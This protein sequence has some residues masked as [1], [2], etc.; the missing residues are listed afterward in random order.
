[1]KKRIISLLLALMIILPIMSKITFKVN[2]Q[3]TSLQELQ[4]KYPSGSYWNHY[5]STTSECGDQLAARWDERY[6][7]SVTN[8]PCASHSATSAEYY[9]GKY[10]CNFFDGA[11]QCMGFAR[12]LGY[13]AFGTK[14]TSWGTHQSISAIKPGDV[15][16]FKNHLTPSGDGHTVFVTG[17]SGT[18]ITV[19]EA[20][21]T[22]A[23]CLIKWGGT[24]DLSTAWYIFVWSAPERLDTGTSAR[25][26]IT[27]T[28]MPRDVYYIKSVANDNYVSVSWGTDAQ[29]QGINTWV[30][31]GYSEQQMEIIP[32]ASGYKIHPM[33]STSRVLNANGY[34]VAAGQRVD[35]WDDV[36]DGTQWWGFEKV[37]G[38]TYIIR[39]MQNQNC[40]LA[41]GPNGCDLAVETYTGSNN[42]L[43]VVTPKQCKHSVYYGTITTPA[44]CTSPG[45]MTHTCGSC[46]HSYTEAIPQKDH[47]F[48]NIRYVQAN[49]TSI[50]YTIYSCSCG[51]SY[52]DEPVEALGHSYT[53]AC[54]TSCNR[55]GAARSITHNYAGATCT[56]PKTCT[57]CGVTT[58]TSLGHT[59]TNAC[60][61]SCNRC[62]AART[63]S[64]LYETTTTKATL[65]KNGSIVPKCSKC[66][67]ASN[68]ITIPY[69]KTVKLSTT[70]Y[71]YDGKVKTPS[72][73]VK[74]AEG[75]VLTKGT[76]Y[77]VSYSSGRKSLGTYKV[78]ITMKGNYSGTKTLTYKIDLATPTVK[79]SNATNGVKITWNKVA[80]AK[81][82]KVYKSVYS[83]GKWSSWVAIKT[84]V[85]GTTYTDTTVK[86]N[87]N[88]K[89]TVRA[90]NGNYSSTY[91][92]S[93]SIKFL[94][95]PTV[96]AENV[97]KGVAVTWNKIPGAKSYIVYKSVYT[98]G[99][100]SSWSR[101]A[102][103]V[104]GT[105]YTDTT[106]KSGA[107]VRYAV[108]AI[109]GS[110]TS[111]IKASNSIKFLATPTVKVAK[112]TTGIKASW[113]AVGSAKGYIV[114]RRAYSGGKWGS[115]AAIKTTTAT[116]YTDTS[117]KTGVTYQ[118]TVRAYNGN[119][120]G[121]FVGSSSIKK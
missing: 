101:V 75:N 62:G 100:W 114:Y 64:H 37:S 78:T 54:D 81:N 10:D 26:D 97:A 108:K 35:L 111:Y 2:A 68:T 107:N 34:S 77:T 84:G 82:Y 56:A 53:N 76:D 24:Y 94:A 66:N 30:F 11:M 46:G 92:S 1:M 20:N 21:F 14:V 33:C 109:N 12:R 22:N 52:T 8:Y 7:G 45:V 87:D 31:N 40:V 65:T 43:W 95:T 79:V 86:S 57:V 3:V 106:V 39:N 60:D 16:Q 72:V 23:P 42:Q 116:S 104:T 18:V 15:V 121:W 47:S 115:W 13:E 19:A 102:T 49:C 6:G 38:D 51:A 58:G 9:V 36:N 44:T 99:A 103:D 80:G 118:Y 67:Q 89:Y 96:K 120:K 4:A 5:V 88:V 71:T 90:F 112:T 48:N 117:A 28:E 63:A 61:A 59:Y 50:G 32:A 91:K 41:V 69:V 17:I 70:S 25:P 55:C 113:N 27:Y 93:S 74:D 105:S 83:G 29:G 119:F 110:F 85:T 98:N 73:T